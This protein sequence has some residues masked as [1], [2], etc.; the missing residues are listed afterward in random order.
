MFSPIRRVVSPQ[1]LRCER[2]QIS[3]W[4][5][6]RDRVHW[7]NVGEGKAHFLLISFQIFRVQ[8][9]VQDPEGFS[10]C[11]HITE[12]QKVLPEG[13][14][15]LFIEE[16]SQLDLSDQVCPLGL[17]CCPMRRGSICWGIIFRRNFPE[18]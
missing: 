13:Q 5:E 14:N 9:S 6:R 16:A 3:P 15:V 12:P 18:K 4:A 8:V 7:F 2:E 17:M 11:S 10:E 1:E